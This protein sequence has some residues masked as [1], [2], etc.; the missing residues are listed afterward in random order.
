MISPF[1]DRVQD[2]V[3]T[4][5]RTAAEEVENEFMGL[6]RDTGRGTQFYGP[7]Y[8]SPFHVIAIFK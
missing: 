3:C 6:S 5:Q 1:P 7:V 8:N 4:V 2:N